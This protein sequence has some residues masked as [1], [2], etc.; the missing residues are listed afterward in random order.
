MTHLPLPFKILVV[1]FLIAIFYSLGSGLYYLI[2]DGGQSPRLVKALIW[3]LI[4]S[5][6]LFAILL[7]AFYLGKISPHPL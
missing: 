1:V 2:R 3:R 7:L 4:L 6:V 5:L